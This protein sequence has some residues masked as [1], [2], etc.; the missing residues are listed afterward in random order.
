MK[1]D[2]KLYNLILPTYVILYY[3]PND[4][5]N[6]DTSVF[7]ATIREF[8]D[9]Q[10]VDD[11]DFEAGTKY[12]GP[13]NDYEKMWIITVYHDAEEAY[14]KYT[15]CNNTLLDYENLRTDYT[16]YEFPETEED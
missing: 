1:K 2:V 4:I 3:D 14:V 11:D 15:K 10:E 16:N 9:F 13:S 8:Y 6:I 5:N 7:E 12:V